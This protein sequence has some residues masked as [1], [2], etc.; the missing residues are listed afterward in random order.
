MNSKNPTV[1]APT[2]SGTATQ[3]YTTLWGLTT[4]HPLSAG[5]RTAMAHS[6]ARQLGFTD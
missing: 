3:G 4:A 1:T 5:E 2:S 6:Y